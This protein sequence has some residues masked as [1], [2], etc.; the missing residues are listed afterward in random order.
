LGNKKVKP[1]EKNITKY[2]RKKE[3]V[4]EEGGEMKQKR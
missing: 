1:K 4:K 2:R 3:R